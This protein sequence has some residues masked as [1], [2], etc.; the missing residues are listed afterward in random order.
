MALSVSQQGCTSVD[1]GR[2]LPLPFV[3]EYPTDQVLLQA[4]VLKL[5]ST[6]F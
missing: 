4:Q 5:R 2:W 3:T 6:D 1:L